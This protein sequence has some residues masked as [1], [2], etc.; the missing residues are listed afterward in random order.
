MAQTV[1]AKLDVRRF[2]SSVR[3]GRR[4][5]AGVQ[6]EIVEK[7]VDVEAKEEV[8]VAKH[9]LAERAVEETNVGEMEG[10]SLDDS[11][12]G[13]LDLRIEG[14]SRD[15]GRGGVRGRCRK[16]DPSQYQ[17]NGSNIKRGPDS[18]LM[19]PFLFI[20]L[21]SLFYQANGFFKRKKNFSRQSIVLL[22]D[23]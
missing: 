15:P 2:P 3:F 19:F 5:Q 11:L 7:A 4:G 14:E 17:G 18:H 10:S 23:M 1:P 20:D 6:A 9:S 21:I 22:N 12:I 13:N 16:D 8:L